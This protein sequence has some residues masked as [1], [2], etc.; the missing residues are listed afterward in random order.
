MLVRY[1]YLIH[2]PG[3]MLGLIFLTGLAGLFIPRRRTAAGALI[4]VSAAVIIALPVAEHEYT[5]RYAIPAIPLACL[6]AALI[7]R[8]RSQDALAPSPDPDVP[9]AAIPV[10]QAPSVTLT[11]ATQDVPAAPPSPRPR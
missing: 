3:P 8:D 1:Q 9:P 7:L 5:F 2:L 4:W 6:A 10:E 11:P